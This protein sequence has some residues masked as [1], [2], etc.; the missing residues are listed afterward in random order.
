MT[1]KHSAPDVA[2]FKKAILSHLSDHRPNLRHGH[3]CAALLHILLQHIRADNKTT[4]MY[5]PHHQDRCAV[6]S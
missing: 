5:V 4:F 1:V 3:G 2:F 6:Q